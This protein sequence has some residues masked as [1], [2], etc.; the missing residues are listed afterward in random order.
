M[1]NPAAG[2]NAWQG[3]IYQKGLK[4]ANQQ[5]GQSSNCD[6]IFFTVPKP[7]LNLNEINARY[8]DDDDD[9]RTNTIEQSIETRI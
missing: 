4:S 2:Y 8:M 6:N 5:H 1:Q 3:F 7:P 9:D